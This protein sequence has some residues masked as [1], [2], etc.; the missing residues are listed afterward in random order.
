MARWAFFL[1][2][3]FAG[4]SWAGERVYFRHD[5]GVAPAAAKLPTSFKPEQ[6]VWKTPLPPGHSTPCLVGDL[7]VLTTFRKDERE[8][9]TVALDRLTGRERWRRVVPTTTLEAFHLTGSPAASS[10]ASDGERLY[11][12]FGSY[13]CLC[14]DLDGKLLWEKRMGPFQDEFGA[15]SSPV[16]VDGKVVLNEDHDVGSFLIAL[17]A[18]TGET[19]WRVSRDGFVRSYS[20]PVVWSVGGREELVVAGSL[21][22]TGYDPRTGER[23][24]WV[25][26]LSRIVDTTPVLVGDRLFLATWTPGGDDTERIRMEP[27][28]DAL[29]RFD[30][31]GDKRLAS[32]ELP[33]G[34]VRTRFFRID[35]NQ[36]GQLDQ[37]EWEKQS[38][39]FELAQNVALSVKF[40]GRG[41]VTDSHVTWAYRRGL[42]TVPSPL[43]YRDVL[44]MVKDGGIL[45]TLNAA[46]GELLKQG[47]I[48]GRGNYY[49]SIV[50]GDGKVYLCSERGTITVLKAVGTW[51]ILD[52]T[53]LG[54]RIMATP[55]L[56][57]NRIYLRTDEALYCFGSR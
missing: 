41:D 22:L 30:T 5:S 50:G 15:S 14:Y 10:P 34:D 37:V 44:F 39:I 7:L 19:A 20:T 6:V 51:E 24:W 46:T 54:E 32:A 57:E 21:Q 56:T 8:L 53:D 11:V 38:R 16:L 45:T 27:F 4:L 13:G 35:L 47:R 52:A 9:A 36:D 28:A 55:V 26:G 31:N 33:E 12:F 17:D 49:G 25:N 23:L 2:V 18:K 3:A 43:V 29:K 1:V 40:G 42:P 48:E